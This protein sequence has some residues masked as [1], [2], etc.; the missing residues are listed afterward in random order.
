MSLMENTMTRIR[1]AAH[2]GYGMVGGH[3]LEQ[4]DIKSPRRNTDVLPGGFEY[5]CGYVAKDGSQHWL[6]TRRAPLSVGTCA[7]CSK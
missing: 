6:Y 4:I 7:M 3:D 1:H 5:H 2:Y